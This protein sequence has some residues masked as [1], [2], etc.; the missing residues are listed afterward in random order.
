M[1]IEKKPFLTIINFS[2]G[3]HFDEIIEVLIDCLSEYFLIELK[4][5]VQNN[6]INLILGL[7]VLLKSTP[8]PNLPN[9]TC[10]LNLEQLN[11]NWMWDSTNYID[12]LLNYKTID[13]SPN[14]ISFFRVRKKED[15]FFLPIRWHQKFDLNIRNAEK[16]ID[17][18]L[19]GARSARRSVMLN[20][21]RSEGL[22]VVH[23]SELW[24]DARADFL[25]RA[26]I[27]VNVRINDSG[28]QETTRLVS[29]ISSRVPVITELSYDKEEDDYFSKFI[30][31]VAAENLVKRV[32]SIVREGLWK[33]YYSEDQLLN[34]YACPFNLK[35][36]A[37]AE[38]ILLADKKKSKT[39]KGGDL[40]T[41]RNVLSNNKKESGLAILPVIDYA[42]HRHDR[43]H[44]IDDY[45]TNIDNLNNTPLIVIV[46]LLEN[47]WMPEKLKSMLEKLLV[48]KILKSDLNTLSVYGQKL[49]AQ[50]LLRFGELY[51]YLQVVENSEFPLQIVK[52]T[53][54]ATT[55]GFLIINE[56]CKK[57]EKSSKLNPWYKLHISAEILWTVNNN[58]RAIEL[59]M[60]E[61][62]RIPLPPVRDHY[63]VVAERCRCFGQYHLSLTYIHLCDE[64]PSIDL[65]EN[66]Y[67]DA[68]MVKPVLISRSTQD[69]VS[70]IER[71]SCYFEREVTSND[72]G[73]I[74]VGV[75][76]KNNTLPI[77]SSGLKIFD[78]RFT[79]VITKVSR[80]NCLA[81]I[82]CY[83]E[84]DLIEA[85]IKNFYQQDV[86]V[87]V[88]DN[89][90]ND[91]TW[92][93]LNLLKQENPHLI[94][95]RFPE[96]GPSSSYDWKGLLARKEEVACG[97]PGYWILHT[98][99]DE[100]RR[101]PWDGVSLSEG[102]S[103]VEAYGCNAIDFIVLNF[104]P[105]DEGFS[106][107]MNPEQYF[108][109]FELG[110]SSDLKYQIKCWKQGAKRVDLASRGGHFVG[111]E[112]RVV[113]PIKFICKHYPLRS[114]RHAIQKIVTDRRNRFSEDERAK[115]WHSHYDNIDPG[116]S[117]WNWKELIKYSS[118]DLLNIGS[119]MISGTS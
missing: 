97:Y 40:L 100:I 79:K 83:N 81:I 105:I 65:I 14:N 111:F 71:N 36:K 53:F 24:G 1:L 110:N 107:G 115:G 52:E 6:S 58:S 98:D 11:H 78:Q 9:N 72:E 91:G 69:I 73:E 51:L 89:W 62:A 63:S 104:R 76:D 2:S 37:L 102:F 54:K 8:W 96:E 41:V 45:F 68:N 33:N 103:I 31:V 46:E 66:C 117:V 109:Y 114:K 95:E 17:V 44:D 28:L 29:L 5:E 15:V 12:Y 50:F 61:S 108:N 70:A 35:A 99:A 21:I 116:Q 113:F 106:V 88:I 85:V 74:S 19:I 43:I 64:M 7:N 26:K 47:C 90:S 10:I 30:E 59:Y 93:I 34:F 49:L 101:T 55:S 87:Y 86:E 118:L 13:Y 77:L 25:S 119:E 22:I 32:C 27:V 38:F 82:A 67:L 4:T 48:D 112:G 92:E 42:L 75:I 3:G 60:N 16:D 57:F 84:V 23:S 39:L 80:K 18:L 94:I 20:K 56:A